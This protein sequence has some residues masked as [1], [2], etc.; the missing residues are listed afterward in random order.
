MPRQRACPSQ[1]DSASD[2]VTC[3]G[4]STSP[5]EP[6]NPSCQVLFHARVEWWIAS[7]QGAIAMHAGKN[8]SRGSSRCCK[9]L[10]RVGERDGGVSPRDGTRRK[11]RKRRGLGWAPC[12]A[13]EAEDREVNDET[14]RHDKV[15][16]VERPRSRR[17]RRNHFCNHF[18]NHFKSSFKLLIM[19]QRLRDYD[20]PGYT[21]DIRARSIFLSCRRKDHRAVS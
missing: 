16:D 18:S 14:V 1:M 2:N 10:L 17:P 8:A 9:S 13:C 3:I 12:S 19:I 21:H 20:Y 6:M 15:R 4:G 7:A 11:R 5:P